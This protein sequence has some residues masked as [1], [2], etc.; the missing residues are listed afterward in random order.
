MPTKFADDM[1]AMIAAW[2][3]IAPPSAVALRLMA[4]IEA[5]IESFEAQRG[6]L[7]FEDEPASFEA[8]LLEV[9]ATRCPA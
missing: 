1:V 2:H 5:L 8:A 9:A 3:G 4:D 7:A 6:A